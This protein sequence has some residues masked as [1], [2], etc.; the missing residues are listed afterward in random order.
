MTQLFIGLSLFTT[1]FSV[2]YILNQLLIYH[3][4]KKVPGLL[5]L[6]SGNT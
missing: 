2:T 6:D 4:E 1:L 3:L 5:I